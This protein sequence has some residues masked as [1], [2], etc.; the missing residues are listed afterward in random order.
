MGL[1]LSLLCPSHLHP[2][3]LKTQTPCPEEPDVYQLDLPSTPP[4]APTGVSFSH[5]P[6]PHFTS[7]SSV[8]ALPGFCPLHLPSLIH[9]QFASYVS[10]PSPE[11]RAK[12]GMYGWARGV[13][14][15]R[16]LNKDR[17]VRVPAAPSA[18]MMSMGL[19]THL[20]LSCP[21]VPEPGPRDR[22]LPIFRNAG[23]SVQSLSHSRYSMSVYWTKKWMK[24]RQKQNSRL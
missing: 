24:K 13:T 15:A 17:W 11:P 2:Q 8:P 9:P 20:S 12:S 3:T 18:E 1:T 21:Q 16:E 23:W 22:L 10:S 7:S 6:L 14:D 5:C 4:P 19:M